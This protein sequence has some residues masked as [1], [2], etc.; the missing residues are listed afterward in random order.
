VITDDIGVTT[1]LAPARPLVLGRVA[2]DL[3]VVVPALNEERRIGATLQALVSYLE[4]QAWSST[5]AVVDNG[6]SDRTLEAVDA[7][8]SARVPVRVLGC[9]DRGKGAAVRRGL[10]T[11]RARYVGF[12]DADLSTPVETLGD[13]VALL[14]RGHRVVIGSRRCP[15]ARYVTVQ[16]FTR[17]L[18]GLAF[19]RLARTVAPDVHDTQCGFKFFEAGVAR[20][21][22]ARSRTEGFAFDVEVLGL[23]LS[24]GHVVTEVPVAWSDARGSSFRP[25]ADGRFALREIRE[26][27]SRLAE[28][29]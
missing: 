19:R 27:R 20:E 1:L 7:V 5:I 8:T 9:A 26:L 21:L 28:A 18:G 11:T 13:V 12:C 3:E 2:A 16:P 17:R 6:C 22:F 29:A 24:A 15:G 23:A 10:T 25:I 14:E 4:V